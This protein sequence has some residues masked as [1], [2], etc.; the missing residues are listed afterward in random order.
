MIL[1]TRENHN[2]MVVAVLE[3]NEHCR[4]QAENIC[5]HMLQTSGRS[6]L[7]SLFLDCEPSDPFCGNNRALL[8]YF[9]ML[10]LG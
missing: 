4:I 8:S 6:R 5:V 3:Y 2:A 9:C 10:C 1:Y 7:I